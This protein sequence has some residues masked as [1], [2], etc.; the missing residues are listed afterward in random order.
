MT[1]EQVMS[2]VA[3]ASAP[4]VPI[5][6]RMAIELIAMQS[7]TRPGGIRADVVGDVSLTHE[8]A[9]YAPI[10]QSSALLIAL[11]LEPDRL[12]ALLSARQPQTVLTLVSGSLVRPLRPLRS[13]ALQI[14]SDL[15]DEVWRSLGYDRLNTRG[16]QGIGSMVWALGERITRRLG[17]SELADRCRI[18][19]Q[20]TVPASH[21]GARLSTILVREYRRIS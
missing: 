13:H 1:D 14:A 6:L 8:F 10:G 11:S 2:C 18:A 12:A 7:S 16:F 9:F 3:S 21:M 15:S 19:M 5:E 17:R 4:D 20:R